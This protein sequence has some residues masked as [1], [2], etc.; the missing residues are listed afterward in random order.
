MDVR[1]SLL[2]N[3]IAVSL[4]RRYGTEEAVF[5]YNRNVEVDFYVPEAGSAIPFFSKQRI[6]LFFLSSSVLSTSF[7]L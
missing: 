7:I 6:L 2:E 1:I 5:F 4:I 3:L